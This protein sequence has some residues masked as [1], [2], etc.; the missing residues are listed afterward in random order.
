MIL[1][2]GGLRQLHESELVQTPPQL[3]PLPLQHVGVELELPHHF[4]SFLLVISKLHNSVSVVGDFLK[5]TRIFAPKPFYF[6]NE[7]IQNN[8]F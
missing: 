3:G 4:G 2:V 5:V 1:K 8:H 7:I 6:G